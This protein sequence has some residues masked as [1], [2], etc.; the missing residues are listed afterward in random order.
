MGAAAPILGGLCASLAKRL[1]LARHDRVAA[2]GRERAAVARAARADERRRVAAEM[3]DTLGHLL[4]LLVLRANVLMVRTNDPAASEAA[5]QMSR[6]GNEGL[7]ELRSLLAR[8]TS[9][10]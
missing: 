9:P 1:N 4:T 3:H 8:D 7:A 10:G 5:E 2:L 6:L